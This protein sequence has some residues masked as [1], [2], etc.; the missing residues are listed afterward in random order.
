MIGSTRF[1][2]VVDNQWMGK[3]AFGNEVRAH[4]LR[5]LVLW[6]DV[7]RVE[8]RGPCCLNLSSRFGGSFLLSVWR[9]AFEKLD[10]RLFE[11]FMLE[12]LGEGGECGL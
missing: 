4:T 11:F 9:F 3:A 7:V 10:E 5:S 2:A 6:G 8:A 1:G 12:N